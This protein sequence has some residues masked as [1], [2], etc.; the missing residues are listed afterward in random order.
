MNFQL[1]EDKLKPG[2]ALVF[3]VNRPLGIKIYT[4][5]P[6]NWDCVTMTSLVFHIFLGRFFHI[7]IQDAFVKLSKQSRCMLIGESFHFS[8]IIQVFAP[9]SVVLIQCSMKLLIMTCLLN[10]GSPKNVQNISIFI[11]SSFNL[12]PSLK[13]EALQSSHWLLAMMHAQ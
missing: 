7:I 3:L 12:T 5:L 4:W 8:R 2:K 9:L 1:C 10:S 13:W 6:C 11:V